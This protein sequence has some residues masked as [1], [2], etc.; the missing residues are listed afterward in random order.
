[1][2][3][4]YGE[5]KKYNQWICWKFV[6]RDGRTRKV[7]VNPRT[8]YAVSVTD[9]KNFTSYKEAKAAADLRGYGMGFVLTED[10]DFIFLDIDKCLQP[11]GT[12]SP[13]ALRLL[14]RL[15][16]ALC[17]VSVSG[18]GLHVIGKGK[19]PKGLGK[20]R[21][22]LG[23]EL[24][25]RARYIAIGDVKSARGGCSADVTEGMLH[26]GLEFFPAAFDAVS[27]KWTTGPVAGY[28]GPTDD[29]VLIEKFLASRPASTVFGDAPKASNRD[30]WELNT[31]VLARQF[32]SQVDEYGFDRSA[33]D[34]SMAVRLAWWTG[35]DCERI[36]RLM[37]DS[38]LMRDKWNRHKHY[39]RD[40]ITDAVAHTEG[41]MGGR[42]AVE[43]GPVAQK[44]A[45]GISQALE[46]FPVNAE[47]VERMISGSFWSGQKSKVF[48]LTRNGDLVQFSEKDSLSHLGMAYGAIVDSEAL[49]AHV[50]AIAE[51]RGLGSNYVRATL[52][53]PGR[54]ILSHLKHYNQRDRLEM[55][56]D[57]FADKGRMD[58]LD[59]K[60]RV[61]FT[62]KPYVP[63]LPNYRQDVIDDYMQHF[64]ILDEFL[65][66]IVAARFA[67]TRK[68]AYM[69][70]HCTSDWG[71]GLL[72]S[73]LKSLGAVV[74]VSA[75][76][77]EGIFEGRPVGK[78][79]ADFKRHMI[80]LVDEFKKV[81]SE[82]KQLES[83]MR[84][85]A[86][87]QLEAR[88]ELFAKVFTSAESVESLA[89]DHG[90]ED[91]F[92]NRFSYYRGQGTINS[93]PL[94]I[95]IGSAQY[96]D[97]L[98]TFI[99]MA[100]NT[101]IDHYIS[102]GKVESEKVGG[103]YL[104]A[105]HKANGI[106]LVH[107]RF[108]NTLPDTA[109]EFLQWAHQQRASSAG[110][111]QVKRRMIFCERSGRWHLASPATLVDKWL[112]SESS[113]SERVSLGRKKIDLY[114]LMSADGR[115]YIAHRVQESGKVVAIRR[116]IML[117]NVTL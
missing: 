75:T 45:D 83:E 8:G 80:L 88:V 28:D 42:D 32:P 78:D 63:T 113:K 25:D 117:K 115:G 112:E 62:H 2:S 22:D 46:G 64:P 1:M 114:K 13:L 108:S 87:Y 90:V 77:I 105:F 10:D 23:I 51:E 9:P 7:P 76:E 47:V 6:E 50:E 58:L 65:N 4:P 89:G 107:N 67:R 61:V 36:E 71:K 95:E 56:V 5:M 74:E 54:R 82:M 73:S 40:T 69:W 84:V 21:D 49:K 106:E 104:V 111:S 86:K 12:W 19:L 94:F 30:L 53:I 18:T 99:A 3:D 24:Y 68:A 85:S 59:E 66:F 91:Q 60:V 14:E 103:D 116:T 97:N 26:I 20:R 55:R 48:L 39:L 43:V 44:L 70:L 37:R 38:P 93:R 101:K 110:D 29:D 31:D 100:M 109:H 16:G 27:V 15:P 35:H 52:A 96:A 72:M 79:I 57:M 41:F 102:L 17:E 92:A 11:D 81:N 34:Y 33:V 98:Q